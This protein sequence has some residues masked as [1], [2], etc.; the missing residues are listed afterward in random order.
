MIRAA[1]GKLLGGK[2]VGYVQRLLAAYSSIANR[3]MTLFPSLGTS[4]DCRG[5]T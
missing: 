1:Q 3:A 4:A 5:L 2:S